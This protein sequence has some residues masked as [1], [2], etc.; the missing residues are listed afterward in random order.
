MSNRVKHQRGGC[1]ECG[2]DLELETVNAV[3]PYKQW[4]CL[5]LVDPGDDQAEFQPCTY[6]REYRSRKAA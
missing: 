6:T 2:G 4:R 3:F 1:P 5:G